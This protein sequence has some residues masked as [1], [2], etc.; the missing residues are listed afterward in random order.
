MTTTPAALPRNRWHRPLLAFAGVMAGLALVSVGG[1]IVDD[2][3]LVAAPIWAKPL[4]FSISFAFYSLALA[5]MLTFVTRARRLANGIGTVV[6]LFGAIEVGIIVAQTVRG[7]RSHFNVA[8]DFDEALWTA[9]GA[10]IAVFWAGTLLLAVILFLTNIPDPASRW[11][12]RMGIVF[13]LAGMAVAMLMLRPTPTQEVQIAA[14]VHT[15]IGAHS[16]GVEDGGPA[17][18]FTGWSTTGGDL[19]IP[20]F[21]GMHGL[22]T[23]PLL[24]LLLAAYARSG[25]PG[26]DRLDRHRRLRLVVLASGLYAGLLA[27]LTWQAL[28]G[29]PLLQPDVAT[30]TAGGALLV[31]AVLGCGLILTRRGPLARPDQ[32]AQLQTVR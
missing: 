21:V 30:A 13:A 5:W 17:M 2:R 28:R 15:A 1:L 19:Q 10:T 27:L 8:T 22:Q 12:I 32:P 14:D 16:V 23:M 20:H 4:K 25:R 26:A 7:Q 24:A 9:M 29:Q 18:P 31:A 3:V 11:A 6:A